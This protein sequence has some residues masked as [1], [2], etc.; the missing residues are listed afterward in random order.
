M[1]LALAVETWV[2][3]PVPSEVRLYAP[4]VNMPAVAPAGGVVVTETP[5]DVAAATVVALPLASMP[6]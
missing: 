3:F 6:L 4:W 1:A 2:E 5:N